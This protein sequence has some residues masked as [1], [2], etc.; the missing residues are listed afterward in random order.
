MVISRRTYYTSDDQHTPTRNP[1]FPQRPMSLTSVNHVF[2]TSLAVS[3]NTA[4]VPSLRRCTFDTRLKLLSPSHTT[5]SSYV[6]LITGQNVR[7]SMVCG[8]RGQLEL[9]YRVD[10]V[11]GER[12]GSNWECTPSE[13]FWETLEP[14]VLVP[15]LTRLCKPRT[16]PSL[17]GCY[18]ASIQHVHHIIQ[19]A[20]FIII[21]YFL[22]QCHNIN[23]QQCFV[24]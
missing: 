7:S 23:Q 19:L 9:S 24:T 15:H 13:C 18:A 17:S 20:S 22:L 1:P 5:R 14:A 12:L 6:S 21:N 2:D 10:H 11:I 4:P 16:I 8:S 3:S